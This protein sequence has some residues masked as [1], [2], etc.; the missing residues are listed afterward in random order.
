MLK[1]KTLI[2]KIRFVQARIALPVSALPWL[3]RKSISIP[4]ERQSLATQRDKLTAIVLGPTLDSRRA[5]AL[6][7]NAAAEVE[8]AVFALDS[9]LEEIRIAGTVTP[10]LAALCGSTV[11]LPATPPTAAGDIEPAQANRPSP[12]W[13]AA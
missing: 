12:L 5:D 9:L 10:K 4:R 1:L 7:A 13:E 6:Q 11:A 8:K 2:S 3:S